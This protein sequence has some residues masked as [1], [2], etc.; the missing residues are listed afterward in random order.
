MQ[1]SRIWL[2]CSLSCNWF[3][4]HMI[5]RIL[6]G[7]YSYKMASLSSKLI[8]NFS[9]NTNRK[10][11]KMQTTGNPHMCK[12]SFCSQWDSLNLVIKS[13]LRYVIG[14]K[15]TLQPLICVIAMLF[16]FIYSCRIVFLSAFMKAFN[17]ENDWFKKLLI[18]KTLGSTAFVSYIGKIYSFKST[19][20]L[21]W[22]EF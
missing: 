22:R 17:S 2:L 15:L 5:I 13:C 4:L 19:I 20:D 6:C 8:V 12:L 1:L 3:V 16:L 7:V 9:I 11:V 18:L 10:F 21:C 14:E